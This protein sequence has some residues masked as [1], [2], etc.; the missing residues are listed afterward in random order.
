MDL[1]ID[2]ESWPLVVVRWGGVVPDAMVDA[3][4]LRMDAWLER[5]ERFGLLVDSRGAKGLSPEQRARLIGH[6]KRQ[7]PLTSRLLVQAIVLDNLIQRSLFY[8][9]NLIFPNPFPSKVFAEPAA[10]REWLLMKLGSPSAADN[11]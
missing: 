5:G 3:F 7:A 6:M 1:P 9:I 11:T 2:E 8:G 4:L 10:A